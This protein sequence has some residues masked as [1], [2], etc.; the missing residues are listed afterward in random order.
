MNSYRKGEDYVDEVKENA[1]RNGLN[2]GKI[3]FLDELQHLAVNDFELQDDWSEISSCFERLKK[4]VQGKGTY[5]IELKLVDLVKFGF[6]FDIID[7][8]GVLAVMH[9][10]KITKPKDKRPVRG[11]GSKMVSE[12]Y[13]ADDFEDDEESEAYHEKQIQT[14]KQ[15]FSVKS[16]VEE[17]DF[18]IEEDIVDETYDRS[19]SGSSHISIDTKHLHPRVSPEVVHQPKLAN[20]ANN[21]NKM[22]SSVVSPKFVS[23][24]PTSSPYKG[25]YTSRPAPTQNMSLD[26]ESEA[27]RAATAGQAVRS[28]NV[29]GSKRKGRTASW[30]LDHAWRLGDKI[31]SGS[32]GEVFQGLNDKVTYNIKTFS[33]SLFV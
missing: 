3:K 29:G 12:E 6:K 30:I 8:I 32:F 2:D 14:E 4:Y 17:E 19:K 21:V 13:Y 24:E 26:A 15:R 11:L 7:R 16:T 1:F 18:S 27:N 28:S 9:A 5:N 22:T 31:G 25:P 10:P 20:N 23:S 33:N